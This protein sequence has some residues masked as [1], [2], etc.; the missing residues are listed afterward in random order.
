MAMDNARV[1]ITLPARASQIERSLTKNQDAS[2]FFATDEVF[3]HLANRAKRRLVIATPFIDDT[4]FRWA[5]S[6]FEATQAGERILLCRDF[7]DIKR[8]SL[9]AV[10]H[11][12][13]LNV[14][15]YEYRLSYE[16]SNGASV[17]E[18]FHAKVVLADQTVSYIGS[19]NFLRSS[20]ERSVECGVLLEG[21]EV[22]KIH[23]LIE[24]MLNISMHLKM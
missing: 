13:R 19:A 10:A 12:K 3:T 15:V 17:M 8:L 4:G 7:D 6:M 16:G 18:T 22:Q 11:L 9:D 20:F 5:S 1:V 21:D 24:A 2:V 23:D 14:R